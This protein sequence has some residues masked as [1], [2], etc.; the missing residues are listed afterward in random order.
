MVI[1][2]QHTTIPFHLNFGT[3][4]QIRDAI[5]RRLYRFYLYQESLKWYNNSQQLTVNRQQTTVN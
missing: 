5:N 4:L 1:F 3:N 2:E